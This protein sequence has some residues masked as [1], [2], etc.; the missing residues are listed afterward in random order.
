[1]HKEKQLAEVKPFKVGEP[2]TD[3]ADGNTEP[4]SS[5]SLEQACVE[6]RRRVCIKCGSEIPHTKYKNAKYCSN[7]CRAAYLAYK[8]SVKKGKIKKPGVGSGGNQ[9]AENNHRYKTGIVSYKRNTFNYKPKVC[10]RCGAKENILVHHKDENRLNNTLDNLEV[11]CKKCHQHHHCN[12]NS[13]TGK[14]I[15]V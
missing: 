10:E 4:S 15:K 13:K 5:N 7:R 12:R 11:L 2:L 9:W 3:N 6:T 14:Y 1:M 8:S